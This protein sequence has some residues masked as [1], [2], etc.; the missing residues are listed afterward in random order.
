MTI[1]N[2]NTVIA[3]HDGI[4]LININNGF[5]S[6]FWSFRSDVSFYFNFWSI[7]VKILKKDFIFCF[8]Q[9]FSSFNIKWQQDRIENHQFWKDRT[10]KCGRGF[11]MT[12][13]WVQTINRNKDVLW[14]Q[15]WLLNLILLQKRTHAKQKQNTQFHLIEPISGRIPETLK[16]NLN[17]CCCMHLNRTTKSIWYCYRFTFQFRWSQSNSNISFSMSVWQEI[18]EYMIHQQKPKGYRSIFIVWKIV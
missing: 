15:N 14:H 5:S 10:K 2:I 12:E 6:D 9:S 1:S 3:M 4:R 16:C 8:N 11:Q 17:G 18:F 7:H 13:Y